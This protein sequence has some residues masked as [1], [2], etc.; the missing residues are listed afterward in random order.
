MEQ[1]NGTTELLNIPQ[2]ELHYTRGSKEG[3]KERIRT[4][5]Q[6]YQAY[7]ESWNAGTIELVMEFKVMYLNT[8]GE[9][10]A[11][12]NVS[13]GGRGQAGVD[14]RLIFGAA[15]KLAATSII[16]C[17]NHPSGNLEI[18]SDA[19]AF[20]NKLKNA[21]QLLDLKMNDYMIISADSYKSMTEERLL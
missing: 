15:L 10:L 19:M 13:S 7:K 2:I 9:V 1:V 18:S 21:A 20:A 14:P 17:T 5:E 6:A 16:C 3:T 12:Y 8:A 11:I 4:P